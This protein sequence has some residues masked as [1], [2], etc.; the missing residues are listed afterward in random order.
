[1][2]NTFM[3]IFY[4]VTKILKT[5]GHQM[6]KIYVPMYRYYIF[7]NVFPHYIFYTPLCYPST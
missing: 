1:M 7:V 6:S 2:S 4:Y 5:F 3:E